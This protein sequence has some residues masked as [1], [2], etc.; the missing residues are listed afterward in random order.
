[1]AKRIHQT[2]LRGGARLVRNGV[3]DFAEVEAGIY[4]GGQSN[5]Q[6]ARFLR[7]LARQRNFKAIF[8]NHK[9]KHNYSATNGP[10]VDSQLE[11]GHHSIIFL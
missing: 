4:R 10:A 2:G 1:M 6:G 8:T 9:P 5:E 3:P 7:S 11:T